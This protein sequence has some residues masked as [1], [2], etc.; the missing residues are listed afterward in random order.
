MDQYIT[1]H[2]SHYGWFRSGLSPSACRVSEGE[3]SAVETVPVGEESMTEQDHRQRSKPRGTQLLFRVGSPGQAGHKGSVVSPST[4]NKRGQSACGVI[5][6]GPFTS[7]PDI[8]SCLVWK[9]TCRPFR[10]GMFTDA[11]LVKAGKSDIS[12]SILETRH[13]HLHV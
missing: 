8:W 6:F 3:D 2:I 5:Q 13:K 11:V 4:G 9:F 1:S 10:V 7:M 12:N